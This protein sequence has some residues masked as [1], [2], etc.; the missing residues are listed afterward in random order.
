MLQQKKP[1]DFVVATG[2]SH[3]VRDFVEEA[4][5][6][7]DIPLTWKGKS[8]KE[9]GVTKGN[10]TIVTIDKE[11]YRPAEV[12]ALCGDATKARTELG[13]KPKVTF[14]ELVRMMTRADLEHYKKSL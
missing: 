10:K 9:V 13:W 2:I 12:R 11:F 14:E 4:C 1:D 5:K 7:L 3:S 8:L 6:E